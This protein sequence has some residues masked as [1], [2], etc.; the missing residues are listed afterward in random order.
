[1]KVLEILTDII[2][3]LVDK[4]DLINIDHMESKYPKL[5]KII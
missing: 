4:N 5:L 3:Y 1:M 2:Y